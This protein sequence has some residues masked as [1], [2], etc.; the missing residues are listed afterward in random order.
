MLFLFYIFL[1]I[2]I[3][4]TLLPPFISFFLPSH[5]SSHPLSS[6]PTSPPSSLDI[7]F[8]SRCKLNI[9][10][11]LLDVFYFVCEHCCSQ[12]EWTGQKLQPK[13]A[14]NRCIPTVFI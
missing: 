10:I 1:P 2:N 3:S 11:I 12:N 4:L 7:S 5:S 13:G 14:K 8:L 6:P 9:G